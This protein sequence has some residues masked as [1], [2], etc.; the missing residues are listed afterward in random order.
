MEH[1]FEIQICTKNNYNLILEIS[2]QRVN[3]FS[4]I[5]NPFPFER[6]K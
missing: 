2:N 3:F 1:T 4:L 5:T 6:M